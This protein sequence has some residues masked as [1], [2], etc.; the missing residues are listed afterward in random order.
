MA[1]FEIEERVFR[2][3]SCFPLSDQTQRAQLCHFPR[4][5]YLNAVARS[6]RYYYR[7][8]YNTYAQKTRTHRSQVFLIARKRPFVAGYQPREFMLLELFRPS[9][10][11]TEGFANPKFNGNLSPS[12][13]GTDLCEQ[14]S[15]CWRYTTARFVHMNAIK[16][17]R[18]RTHTLDIHR[19]T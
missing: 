16:A 19:N 2:T 14:N 18:A 10:E 12:D 1:H 15:R 8:C 4:S 11:Q 9:P 5:A 17:A 6:C 3:L 13:S 7:Y